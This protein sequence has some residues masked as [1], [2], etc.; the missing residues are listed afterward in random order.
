MNADM[1][2]DTT[3]LKTSVCDNHILYKM[4]FMAKHLR[5]PL[6]KTKLLLQQGKSLVLPDLLKSN[7]HQYPH[8]CQYMQYS[9]SLLIL[10]LPIL[11]SLR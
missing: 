4:V 9:A 11:L 8:D 7:I 2:V 3:C 5:R 1:N 6:I 10:I